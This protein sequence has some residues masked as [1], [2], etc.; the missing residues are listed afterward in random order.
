M[1]DGV[2]FGGKRSVTRRAFGDYRNVDGD[3]FA[4]LYGDV[5]GLAVLGYDFATFID[6][7]T[8]SELVPVPG[9]Q[10]F[11]ASLATCF[12]IRCGQKNHVTVEASVRTLQRD[13]GG[14]VGS[15]HGLVVNGATAVDVA[16]LHD[17][18]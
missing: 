8:G 15:Q 1:H 7:V 13:E 17:R 14:Q 6:G 18:A 10:H 4:G 2:V 12:F 11:D 3:F 16:V 5:M 9:D